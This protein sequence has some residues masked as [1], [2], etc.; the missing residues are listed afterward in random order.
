MVD[1]PLEVEYR[2]R[3]GSSNKLK[4]TALGPTLIDGAMEFSLG[5][6]QYLKIKDPVAKQGIELKVKLGD[7]LIHFERLYCYLKDL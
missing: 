1:T 4:L 2:E 3:S 5:D 7:D 6:N